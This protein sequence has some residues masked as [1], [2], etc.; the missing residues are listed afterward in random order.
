[1][2]LGEYPLHI[3]DGRA[4]GLLISLETSLCEDFDDLLTEVQQP[5]DEKTDGDL[6]R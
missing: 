5:F 6:K 1:M 3:A 4:S 2:R